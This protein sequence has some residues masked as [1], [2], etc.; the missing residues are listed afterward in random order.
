MSFQYDVGGITI[1]GRQS[2]ALQNE[3]EGLSP[4]KPTGKKLVDYWY[5]PASPI[6]IE[7]IEGVKVYVE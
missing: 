4:P 6:K 7:T 5:L 2:G 3:I 1:D